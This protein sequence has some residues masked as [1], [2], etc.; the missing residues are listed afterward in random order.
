MAPCNSMSLGRRGTE[1]RRSFA[2][3]F[4]ISLAAQ[5]VCSRGSTPDGGRVREV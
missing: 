5:V 1:G 4:P 3:V 2:K